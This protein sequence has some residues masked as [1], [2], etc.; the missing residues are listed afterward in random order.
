MKIK[1]NKAQYLEKD[2]IEIL[3]T[4]DEENE[5][6]QVKLYQRQREVSYDAIQEKRGKEYL[7][8]IDNLPLG[9]YIVSVKTEN[10]YVET[11]FD[12]V[13]TRTDVVRYGFL[14]DFTNEENEDIEVMREWHLNAVQFYDWMY[15]HDQLVSDEEEYLDPLG[16][17]II[18][19][20]LHKKIVGCKDA[21]MRPIAYGAVYAATKETFEKH[22]EW[23]LYTMDGEAMLFANWLY[24]MNIADDCG[25]KKYILNEYMLAVEKMGFQGIHMD[26]YGFPKNVFDAK[27]EKINLADDFK[28]LIDEAAKLVKK[29]DSEN[30]VIFNAVNNWPVES[31]AQ[32]EQDVVYIEV[33]PPNDQYYDL[34]HLIRNARQLS[35]KNVV[36]AAYMK[37]FQGV[38]SEM[39]YRRAEYSY[40]L[41]NA[42]IC[43]SGGTQLAL[44]GNASI[45]CDSYYVEHTKLRTEFLPIVKKYCDYLVAYADFMYNDSGMDV[46]M[47]ASGGINEDIIF[48]SERTGF[49]TT[50]EAGKVWTIIREQENRLTIHL[51][52]LTNNNGQWNEAKEAPDK[53]SDIRMKVRYDRKLL[54]VYSASPDADTIMPTILESEVSHSN[55]GRTYDIR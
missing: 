13:N 53:V 5:K 12:V 41:T 15:R 33:W 32:S 35:G 54:S 24:Y 29:R 1:L 6:I 48:E 34:Y 25:W 42:T 51:I 2:I 22:P 44:G 49:S 9:N 14:T 11:A 40:L 8:K 31:V 16:R 19:R 4:A 45:L 10:K 28:P 38:T 27:H 17:K 21:G 36:L 39:D 20:C 26:T 55:C 23:A 43:A 3:V 18:S 37:P 50:A 7:I 46:S 52:N 30:G 47:T